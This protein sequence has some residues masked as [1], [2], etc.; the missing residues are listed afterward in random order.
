M[1][2]ML[3]LENAAALVNLHKLYNSL[4][5]FI[6]SLSNILAYGW[7]RGR[8]SQTSVHLVFLSQAVAILLLCRKGVCLLTLSEGCLS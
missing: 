8:V 6:K 7:K 5:L 3:L 1:Q 2:F 4:S